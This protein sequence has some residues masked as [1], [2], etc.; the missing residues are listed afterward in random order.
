MFLTTQVISLE[1]KLTDKT[2]RFKKVGNSSKT[3]QLLSFPYLLEN[4]LSQLT[5]DSYGSYYF[6]F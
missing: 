4:G 3:F 6:Y 5:L 2:K 1:Q